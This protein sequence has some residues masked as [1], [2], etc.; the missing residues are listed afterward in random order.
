MTTMSPAVQLKHRISLMEALG[1]M[2]VGDM[3][4]RDIDLHQSTPA[5]AGGGLLTIS[6]PSFNTDD[7]I[8]PVFAIA[9]PIFIA[10]FPIIGVIGGLSLGFNLVNRVTRMFSSLGG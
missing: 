5:A 1:K 7:L 4:N 8:N 3:K 10:F 6:V 2:L 9:F